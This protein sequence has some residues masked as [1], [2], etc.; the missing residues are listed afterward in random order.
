MVDQWIGR[1]FQ[2]AAQADRRHQHFSHVNCPGG[3]EK[4]FRKWDE[5]DFEVGDQ[6]GFW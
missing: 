2:P 1:F 5:H 3:S 4:H 6:P